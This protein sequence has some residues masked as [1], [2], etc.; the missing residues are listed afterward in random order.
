MKNKRTALVVFGMMLAL[1]TAFGI[2]SAF[3]RERTLTVGIYVDSSWGVP[4]SGGTRVIDQA[5]RRFEKSNPGVR[6]RY[7]NGINKDDYMDWLSEKIVSSKAPDVFIVPYN[8]FNLL[9]S[10]GAMTDLDRY[11]RRDGI[12][13]SM[14]YRGTLM[15]GRYTGRQ[16]ALP[17]ETN[18]M[19]MCVNTDLLKKNG[20]SM[21]KNSW[22]LDD[23]YDICRKITRDT[24]GDGT[25]DQFGIAGYTWQD[26]A[27]AC[28]ARLFNSDGTG[29]DFNSARV[30]KALTMME[31]LNALTG[32]A[33]PNSD[34][35]DKGKVAFLPMTLA[36]YRTYKSYP[37][38]VARYS[39][40]SWTCIKMPAESPTIAGTNSETSLFAVSSQS[41]QKKLAWKFIRMLCCSEEFQQYMCAN[42]QGASVLEKCSSGYD[43]ALSSNGLKRILNSMN[44]P[45]HF[46]KYNTAMD[47]A[48]YLI[49]RALDNRDADV[50]I[51]Q[52]QE[53]IENTLQ[54][55]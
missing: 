47:Q 51:G 29:A 32:N 4:N 11:M 41:T 37:Y 43:S 49:S 55:R 21:P 27:S 34:D 50:E 31:N 33:H 14:F 53:R 42:S 40:F 16:Y 5:I 25:V 44:C 23:L 3:H 1:V 24:N 8:Q 46:R 39:S 22:T 12:D 45:P 9:S 2:F 6:I 15:A 52:I 54:G 13:G 19:M 28:G 20:I 35:F 10:V 17:Y 30:R 38:H 26:A 36:Q 7:E 48:D 18:P